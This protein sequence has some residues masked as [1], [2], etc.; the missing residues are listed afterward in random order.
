MRDVTIYFRNHPSV[1]FWEGGNTSIS[2]DHMTQMRAVKDQWDPHGGR[3]AGCRGTSNDD[4]Q[5]YKATMDSAGD[6][7]T[8]PLWASEYSRAESPRR[9]WDKY[10]PARD[11]F[12][13]IIDSGGYM[14]MT[15]DDVQEYTEP[16]GT[17]FWANSMED[18]ARENL[19]K[20]NDNW[21]RR[22]GIGR[23]SISVGGAKIIF[24]DSESHGRCDLEVA[25]ATGTVDGA[26]LVKESFYALA[27]ARSLVPRVHILGHWN[28]APGTTKNVYVAGSQHC[29]SVQLT[30]HAP[31][32][33][34]LQDYGV[35]STRGGNFF[36]FEFAGVAW[37]PG[38]IRA[39][40]LIGGSVAAEQEK[41][42][43]GDPV[44]IRVTPIVGPQGLIADGSD[45]AMF[46]VE[47]VDANGLRCPT[48]MNE[49][50]FAWSGAS[51]NWLNG[52]NSGIEDTVYDADL[53]QY[54]DHLFVE[55][56]INRV[57]VRATRTP[58]D[59]TLTVT[60]DG[61]TPGE[62]TITAAE[63]SQTDGLTT[64]RPQTYPHPL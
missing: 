23:D 14:V 33:S 7:P 41:V 25:R 13:A 18:L 44:A 42:T 36:E 51:A 10:T 61:L 24:A 15:T 64:V 5:E 31:D 56:G 27:V 59:F 34:L 48:A 29:D 46:D 40:C 63:F 26:R 52:Y 57:F 28:Y 37:Q 11:Q 50:S 19:R 43:A 4:V 54:K 22:A 8:H 60:S 6:S 53:G 21:E 38:S 62:A 20:F 16:N 2:L 39:G 45:I 47:V 3:F 58:G 17:G 49:V 32:G 12:A 35:N 1:M 30:T 55:N 9:I